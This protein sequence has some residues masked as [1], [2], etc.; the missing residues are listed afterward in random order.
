MP[1]VIQLLLFL[2][3]VLKPSNCFVSRH[4]RTTERITTNCMNHVLNAGTSS[5]EGDDYDD[6]NNNKNVV[7]AMNWECVVDTRSYRIPLAIA[8]ALQVWPELK[9]LW[10]LT[11]DH[12]WLLNKLLALSHVFSS[13][14]NEEY[15]VTCEYALA[16]RL[17][18]EEQELDNGESNGKSGKYASQFH[19]RQQ[20]DKKRSSSSSSSSSSTA[21][22]S[23]RP[24]TVG[25]IAVNWNSMIRET[26]EFRYRVITRGD[27][28]DQKDD[29]DDSPS[30]SNPIPVLQATINDLQ[31][32]ATSFL[33]YDPPKVL[34]EY[35]LMDVLG[36]TNHRTTNTILLVSH[37]S[38]WKV[39]QASLTNA[40]IPFHATDSVDD[41]M[42]K[43]QQPLND[44]EKEEEDAPAVVLLLL[45][46]SNKKNNDTKTSITT[47]DLL[48]HAPKGTTLD[49]IESSWE[50]L[51]SNICYFGDY[52][53]RPQQNKSTKCVVP[54]KFLSLHLADWPATSHPTQQASATM[55]PWTNVIS[56][57]DLSERSTNSNDATLTSSS[58][59][60]PKA[61]FE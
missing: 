39:A 54:D 28:A 1:R 6:D 9:E 33:Y 20:P 26:L 32:E 24:L 3:L 30:A 53:P 61:S 15:S 29:D 31:K 14:P 22:S 35:P 7:V 49:V 59:A 4:R 18:L 43:I 27:A 34:P 13:S 25:E 38:D 52:I 48:K 37:P 55:N 2:S 16:T 41:A 5:L 58:T 17:L 10:D 50:R 19:P 57:K 46:L 12:S 36:S 45:L 51:E 8:A 47:L 40:K 23:T 56:W 44:A 60:P 21:S 42:A 11:E